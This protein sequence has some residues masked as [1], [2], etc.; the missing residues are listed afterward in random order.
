MHR[1]QTQGRRSTLVNANGETSAGKEAKLPVIT[2]ERQPRN[3]LSN[4]VEAAPGFEPGNSGF[5]VQ[6]V[7]DEP[8]A[9]N[10]TNT[11]V[12]EN[13]GA[14]NTILLEHLWQ[15]CAPDKRTSLPTASRSHMI[16]GVRMHKDRCRDLS[17][18]SS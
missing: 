6:Y 1:D 17:A 4:R 14:P 8:G 11:K 13:N 10:G 15:R 3:S 2:R 18:P 9:V 5:A 12:V 16:A 7:A